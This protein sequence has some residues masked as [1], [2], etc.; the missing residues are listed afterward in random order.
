MHMTPRLSAAAF[1]LAAQVEGLIHFEDSLEQLVLW[2]RQV[3]GVC[4]KVDAI[5]DL[6][7]SAPAAN[8]GAPA[9]APVASQG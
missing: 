1:M 4:V 5:L 2:D 6:L 3:A 7:A 9:A 8:G